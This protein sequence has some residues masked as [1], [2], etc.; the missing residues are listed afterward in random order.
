MLTYEPL[1]DSEIVYENTAIDMNAVSNSVN[2][3]TAGAVNAIKNQGSC[4]SCWA[5]SAMASMESTH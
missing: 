2:W 4:G 5:F 1:A 3:V